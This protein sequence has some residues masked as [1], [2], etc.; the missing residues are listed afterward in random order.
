MHW[1]NVTVIKS[2][3]RRMPWGKPKGP[4]IEVYPEKEGQDILLQVR[5]SGRAAEFEAEIEILDTER[6]TGVVPKTYTPGWGNT[7]RRT[8]RIKK[9]GSDTVRVATIERHSVADAPAAGRLSLEWLVEPSGNAG[10]LD[11]DL[12]SAFV[13]PK[14]VRDG[15]RVKVIITADPCPIDGPFVQTYML[16]FD[17]LQKLEEEAVAQELR[18]N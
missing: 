6:V 10:S 7:D 16:T 8:T 3:W 12:G 11:C 1:P 17:G 4:R 15:C 9:G 14:G 18:H 5:N 2:V 13:G